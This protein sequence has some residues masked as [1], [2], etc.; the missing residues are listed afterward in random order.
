MGV[1]SWSVQVDWGRDGDFSEVIE[2]QAI[3]SLLITRGRVDRVR[4]DGMGQN[5]P[6]KEAFSVE[7]RDTGGR[8]DPFN[9]AGPLYAFL[10][11]PGYAIR[12]FL[13]G[14]GVRPAAAVFYGTLEQVKYDSVH[15]FANLVGSGL[16]RLLEM[17][18]AE[19]VYT[20]CQSES[21]MA[22]DSWFL[23][24]PLYPVPT[25]TP[26]NYWQG[27]PDG[28]YLKECVDLILSGAGWGFGFTHHPLLAN[29]EQPEFFY[30]DGSTAWEQLKGVADAF[31]A[32]LFFLR[33]GRLLV[34]DRLDCDGMGL[35]LTSPTRALER[36]GLER[37]AGLDNLRNTIEV[38]VRPRAVELFN[39]P[40]VVAHFSLVWS[41]AGP[42]AVPPLGI[43]ELDVKYRYGGAP[44]EGS[45]V[46]ANSNAIAD[47][48]R[49]EVWSRP[50]KSGTDMGWWMGS[51]EADF[52]LMMEARGSNAYGTIYVPYGDNQSQS[53][54][55]LINTSATL[56]AYFF[57]LQVQVIAMLETG[58]NGT[59]T[60]TDPASLALNGQR[61]LKINSPWVQDTVMAA[62]IAHAYGYA[63]AAREAAA[64]AVIVYQW[65]DDLL[66]DNLLAYD[67]GMV[68]NFGNPGLVWSTRN[69]GLTGKWL[70]VG[71]EIK[72]LSPDGQDAD[73]TLTFEKMVD[74]TAPLLISGLKLW[75]DADYLRQVNGTNV[76][77]WTDR[78]GNNNHAL[79]GALASQPVYRVG[80]AGLLLRAAVV[81]DNVNDFM[82]LTNILVTSTSTYFIV[83]SKNAAGTTANWLLSDTGGSYEYYQDGD[84]WKQTSTSDWP[85]LTN[86]N[87]YYIRQCVSDVLTIKRYANGVSTSTARSG[88]DARFRYLGYPGGACNSAIAEV[89]VYDRVL[90]DGERLSVVTYLEKKYG[91]TA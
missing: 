24:A 43:V 84:T 66:Y 65:S 34:M 51:S 46:R 7:I 54:I 16:S 2:P 12:F 55:K 1:L 79:Q 29:Y 33:D 4:V 3:K 22:W 91:R 10:G 28:L 64:P 73:V 68:V 76:P 13:A 25:V 77:N 37:G 88:P 39:N 26:V 85:I 9:T 5:Q 36:Y 17:G 18:A 63:L 38:T 89:I 83:Y 30:L 53:R 42:V 45:F 59:V 44:V 23:P 50:D 35:T 52:I 49:W 56:T 21:Y 14:S 78:S 86:Q 72:W 20:A 62:N 74:G 61:V 31:A 58:N 82:E 87:N 8:Y 57:N 67:V 41:N 81:F 11:A 71:Q 47:P 27:Q 40:S 15:G 90:T 75:L 70:V 69:Y 80:V 19:R 6:E 32:R 60:Y 48:D